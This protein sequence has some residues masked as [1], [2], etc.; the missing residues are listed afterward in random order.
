[1][2][3][4]TAIAPR[5]NAPMNAV[6]LRPC[7]FCNHDEP[8]LAMFRNESAQIIVVTCPECGAIGRDQLAKIRRGMRLSVE[9]AIRRGT[10]FP[11]PKHGA[12]IR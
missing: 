10:R 5:D 1:M 4:A 8:E 3:G 6:N 2:S 12:A 11:V 7:P 9:S